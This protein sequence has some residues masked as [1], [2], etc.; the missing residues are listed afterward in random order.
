[1]PSIGKIQKLIEQAWSNGFD[2]MG[3]EQL[4]GVLFNTTK[5]IGASDVAAMFSFLK[6]KT[7]LVDIVKSKNSNKNLAH[8]LYDYAYR[9]FETEC[10]QNK[11]VYPIFIQHD[12]HSRTIVGIE[13]GK[14]KNLI[15]FDPGSNKK[16]IEEHVKYNPD[17]LLTLLRRGIESFNRNSEYQLLLIKGKFNSDLELE[18]IILNLIIKLLLKKIIFLEC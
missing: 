18:V 14:N 13:N 4:G 5:W 11:F 2:L 6:I 8:V 3:K 17:R 16:K 7:E 10:S 9:Y 15:I 1:M 12:G